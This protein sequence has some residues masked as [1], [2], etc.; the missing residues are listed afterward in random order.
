MLLTALLPEGEIGLF[1]PYEEEP[2]FKEPGRRAID[3]KP[4]AYN[5]AVRY[6][7][8]NLQEKADYAMG[9]YKDRELL[10]I[11]RT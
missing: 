2:D 3:G 8:L 5:R 9:A 7:L 1:D 6:D 4:K 10:L 11:W